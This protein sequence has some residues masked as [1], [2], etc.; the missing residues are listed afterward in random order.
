MFAL[1][2]LCYHSQ[3][4]IGLVA[5][6]IGTGDA[7]WRWV[8]DP[9]AANFMT[10]IIS[11]ITM[12][13]LMTSLKDRIFFLGDGALPPPA[14]PTPPPRPLPPAPAPSPPAPSPPPVYL[15]SA[16]KAWKK[17]EVKQWLLNKAGL[18]EVTRHRMDL[19]LCEFVLCSYGIDFVARFVNLLRSSLSLCV[20]VCL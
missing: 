4:E 8:L 2:S 15:E 11:S 3:K 14:P 7:L 19:M 10:G 6:M 20:C 13:L 17:P 16:I 9:T 18:S 12:S 5:S 1:S